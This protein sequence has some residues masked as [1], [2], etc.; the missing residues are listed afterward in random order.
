MRTHRTTG[1]IVSTALVGALAF[2]TAGTAFASPDVAPAGT[3]AGRTAP[4]APDPAAL[5]AQVTALGKLGGVLTPVTDAVKA[6]LAA[7]G[8][9]LSPAEITKHTDAIKAAIDAAKLPAAP[10][11]P[12]AP[13]APAVPGA[14]AVPA[15]PAAPGL[16]AAPALP[17]APLLP[18][19]PGALPAAP[20]LPALP[21]VPRRGVIP[22]DVSAP[23]HSAPRAADVSADALAALQAAVADLLKA[24]GSGDVAGAAAGALKVVTG[25]VNVL[26]AAV[27]GGGLPAPDLPGLPKLPA[28]PS[29]PVPTPPLPG[30]P[31]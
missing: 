13:A 27:L 22:A 8:N 24:A 15:L 23:R 4:A 14:P 6:V 7:P 30:L 2:G 25:L 9:K 31:G 20:A 26:V 28:L 11:V 29:L 10:A 16:P 12:A 19:T 1:V 21:G 5:L 18:A 3:F 17:A